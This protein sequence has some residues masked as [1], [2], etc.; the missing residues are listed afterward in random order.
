MLD[1][2]A[3]VIGLALPWTFGIALIALA[4]ARTP[5]ASPPV[6]WVVGCGW[7]VGIFA[8]TLLMRGVAAANVPLSIASIGAPLLAATAVLAPLGSSVVELRLSPRGGWH[9]TLASGLN[10]ALGRGDWRPRAERFIAAWPRIAPE[11]RA[12]TYADL[13][14]PGGFALKRTAELTATS[15]P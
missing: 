2:L 7:F 8:T 15:K 14:Y 13:R 3:L 10:V 12:T 1:L 11:A 6:G 4:Y 5:H 9:A